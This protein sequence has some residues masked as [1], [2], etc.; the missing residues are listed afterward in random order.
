MITVDN[1]WSVRNNT[2]IFHTRTT[3]SDSATNRLNGLPISVSPSY[4]L[5]VLSQ[6]LKIPRVYDV[7]AVTCQLR[8]KFKGG[9]GATSTRYLYL[10][11]GFQGLGFRN[12]SLLRTY[13][14]LQY[15]RIYSFFGERYL[16]TICDI[17]C[18]QLWQHGRYLCINWCSSLFGLQR[19]EGSTR[20][21]RLTGHSWC[22]NSLKLRPWW[23]YRR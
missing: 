17:C 12:P 13:A 16:S 4:I 11:V 22:K 14:L 20:K 5:D 19:D 8:K 21:T 3:W 1:I 7:H 23:F 2:W 6:A 18:L 10:N 9:S 15:N